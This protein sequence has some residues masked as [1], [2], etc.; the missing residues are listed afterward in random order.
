[1]DGAAL[2]FLIV[3]GR[4]RR[5]GVI[6][7]WETDNRITVAIVEKCGGAIEP[8]RLGEAG[9]LVSCFDIKNR[10]CTALGDEYHDL[11][12]LPGWLLL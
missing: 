4:M 1:M 10:T 8:L 3:E 12:W 9:Q 2:V 7:G 11:Q 5:S 6:N